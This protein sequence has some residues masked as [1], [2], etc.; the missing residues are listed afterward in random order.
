MLRDWRS[1][2]DTLSVMEEGTPVAHGVILWHHQ[3][4][5]AGAKADGQVETGPGGQ[6]AVAPSSY[7]VSGDHKY[8]GVGPM[9]QEYTRR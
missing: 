4:T 1:P 8:R 6:V 2:W 5:L 7:R 3:L 9:V